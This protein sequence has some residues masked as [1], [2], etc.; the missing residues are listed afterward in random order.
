MIHHSCCR[1]PFPGHWIGSWLVLALAV[2]SP[3][4][5][6]PKAGDVN[7]KKLSVTTPDG[8]AVEFELGTL[9]VPEN[10]NDP[11]SRI[12]GV[13]FA[14]F[15]GLGPTGAPPTFHLPG[16]PGGSYVSGMNLTKGDPAARKLNERQ[17][18]DLERY[19]RQGDV[20]YVDQRGCTEL[21]ER[22]TFTYQLAE[23]P[24]TEPGSMARETAE[25]V[26]AARA[27]VADAAARKIDLAGYTIIE[28]AADVND[29]RRALGYERVVLIGQSFGGQWSFATMRRHPGIVARAVI[30]GVEP[31]DCGYDMPSHI[32]ASMRRQWQA[33]E[34][35]PAF[36]RYL[37]PGGMAAAVREIVR[38][39]EKA[40]LQVSFKDESSGRTLAVTLGRDDFR[41]GNPA[42]ILAIYHG[43]YEAW[44]RN[45]A[46]QRRAR[47]TTI[48]LIGPLIDTALAVTPARRHLLRTDPAI[49]VLGEWNFDDYMATEDIWPTE[50]VGD[51]FRSEVINPTPVLFVQGDWDTS[52]PMENLVHVQPFFPN[53]RT[54]LVHQGQ[55]GA[56]ARVRET[57]PEATAAIM[58]F[59]RTGNTTNLPVQVTVPP[60]ALD[61]PAFP[62]PAGR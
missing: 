19:R 23:K 54:V 24:L 1:L 22:L 45:V 6:A 15:R 33:V 26:A 61:A 12:I 25:F 13:G 46:R 16:G 2:S 62:P 48:E 30:S 38:R 4:L 14:R 55:H 37:P 5:A 17:A 40:P 59:I 49:A 20:V 58:E 21:G 44:A 7:I 36:E 51:E 50:D 53:S 52:T 32:Y 29:L 11:R 9:H 35:E 43:H 10:R 8:G 41:P 31:L 28:C 3:L 47:T 34:R 39:L 60:P 27:A 18:A 57:L 56:Y 42:G